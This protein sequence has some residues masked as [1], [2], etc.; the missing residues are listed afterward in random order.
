M[1]ACIFL[2]FFAVST[3][4]S[5]LAA[6]T[7]KGHVAQV[8]DGQT[9]DVARDN[10]ETVRIKLFAVKAPDPSQ[11]HADDAAARLKKW[12]HQWGDVATV[13]PMSEE[14]G[15][16]VVARVIVGQEDLANVLAKAC[17]A[18]INIQLCREPIVPE[19]VGW[20]AWELQCRDEQK[21]LWAQ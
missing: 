21:G 19:C 2:V 8:V 15:G 13:I 16:A 11:P 5:A 7:W 14:R 18:R 9:L 20:H 10:G 6:E 1:K 17:L 4:V 12:S 3:S